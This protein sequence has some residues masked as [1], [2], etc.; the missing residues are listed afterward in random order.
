[1]RE[2]IVLAAERIF[3]ENDFHEVLM[4]DV[5]RACGVAKGTV[6]RYFSSKRA[7]YLAVM[8]DGIKRLR[9]RVRVAVESSDEPL[10][11]L[12]RVTYCILEHSWDRRFFLTWI[13]RIEHKPDDPDAREWLRRRKEISRIIERAVKEA[14]AA[15]ALQPVDAYLAT[16]MLLGILRGLIRY[17]RAQDR[18]DDLQE[19]AV[20]TFVGGFG[21]DRTRRRRSGEGKVV[22]A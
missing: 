5:A 16:E 21:T 14:I 13:H 17:R 10:R 22:T 9:D 12:E 8:F 4:E 2:K 11:K 19:L 3:A 7:L 15:G 18:L 1:L 6:Y 20:R